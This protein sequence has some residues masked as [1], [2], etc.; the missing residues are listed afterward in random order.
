MAEIMAL[1]PAL[2][3]PGTMVSVLPA[4]SV[5]DLFSQWS[6]QPVA[7]VAAAIAAVWYAHLVTKTAA[8]PKRRTATFAIGI[9]VFV[10]ATSGYPEVYVSSLFWMW[11]AQLLGLLLIVPI[12]LM[13]G[14]PIDLARRNRGDRAFAVRFIGSGTGRMF[15]NPLV[16]P[17]LIPVLSVLL[18]FG[19]LPGWAISHQPISWVLQV[20]VTVVGALIVLPLVGVGDDSTSMAVALVLVIGIFELL[21]DAVPGIVLRLSTHP[22]TN[23][24]DFRT[25]HPWVPPALRDQQIGGATLWAVAELID[26]PFLVLVYVRW[27][28]A[29]ARDA[30]QIDTVLEAERIARGHDGDS[31][32]EDSPGAVA[33]GP[34]DTPWWL[35]DPMMQRRFRR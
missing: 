7:L 9:L 27:V 35:S 19:P 6:L 32:A 21:L 20:V 14:Q 2:S 1:R 11:T 3:R 25:P 23:F 8:W 31:P 13:A 29:D 28:R 15:T 24:F 4:P 16:G 34:S 17:I 18:F 10:W 5:Q 12:L 22:V 26:L 33:A 30:A